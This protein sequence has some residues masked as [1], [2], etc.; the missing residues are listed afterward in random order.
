MNYIFTGIFILE[1][2]IKIIALG[3]R[4]YF[5]D[6][7]NTFDFIIVLGSFC[8]IF[9]A[10]ATTL[11]IRGATSVFR[12]FRIMRILRLIKRG[13]VRKDDGND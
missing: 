13:T 1:A 6:N 12:A 8:G 4:L 5:N 11:Q 2:L 9:I 3:P 10:F 7:W